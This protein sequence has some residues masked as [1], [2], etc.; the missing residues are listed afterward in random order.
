MRFDQY[1]Q[2]AAG[3]TERYIGVKLEKNGGPAQSS[4]QALSRYYILDFGFGLASIEKILRHIVE[5]KFHSS[6]IEKKNFWYS[7]I[8]TPVRCSIY[9]RKT[10]R[11]FSE[12]KPV[13]IVDIDP[14]FAASEK[15]RVYDIQTYCQYL[16]S[17]KN[18]GPP[19]YITGRALNELMQPVRAEDNGIYMLD[20]A[21]RISAHALAHQDS[22]NAL[23]IMQDEEFGN[24]ID[25]DRVNGLQKSIQK[26]EWFNNYQHIPMAGLKGQRTN[27]RFELMDLSLLQDASVMDFGCNLGQ[28]C[29]KA[30]QAGAKSVIG[31]E[32]MPDTFKLANA[33]KA[34]CTLDPI[35]YLN[36]DFN[37]PAFD[38]LIDRAVPEAVD[39]SFFFSVYRT[40]E[41]IQRDRLF[42]YIIH[43]S[44][45]G[46]F[47]EGHAHA[48]IDTIE[49]YD[50]LFESHGLKYQ[51]LGHSE[52]RL[53]P[54]FYLPLHHHQKHQPSAI[55]KTSLQM[56]AQSGSTPQKKQN[57]IPYLVSAVV[58]T[59][60]S[61]KFIRQ[62]LDDLLGQTI[63]DRL[64]IIVIDSNSPENEG[65]VCREYM[66]RHANI[67]YLRTDA[68][69]TVYQAWNRG[70]QMASGK[71]VTN[72]NTDDRLR[73]DALALLCTHLEKNPDV[74]LVYSD[75]FITHW[76]NMTFERHIRSGYSIKPDYSPHI[77]LQGCHIGPQP[78]WRRSVHDKIG[79][80]SPK[81]ESAGDYEFWCRMATSGYQL[82]HVNDFL[83]LYLHNPAGIINRNQMLAHK[84]TAV[85]REMY[86]H[87]LPEAASGL[88]TG[89]YHHEPARP[90]RYVNI[91]MV[92][93]NRLEFT[94]LAIQSILK[95]TRF[96]YVLTVVDNNS[97]DGSREYLK[98]LKEKGIVTNLLL[99]EDNFGVAKAANMGWLLEPDAEFYLK[100]DNDIVIQKID[101][102]TDLIRAVEQI[103][104]A[105]A[106]A[107]N[108]EPFSY[109]LR[110]LHGIKIRPKTSGNL[111]GACICIPR[112]TNE[113]LG[114]WSEEYG[115]Y[116]EE[117]ADYGCRIPLVGMLNLYMQDENIGLHLPAGRA[118]AIDENMTARDGLEERMHPR[119][120][121]YKDEQRRKNVLTHKF[122]Q[123][124]Q[125]YRHGEAPLFHDAPFARSYLKNRGDLPKTTHPKE[126]SES[127]RNQLAGEPIRKAKRFLSRD[128]GNHSKDLNIAVFSFEDPFTA[129]S[130][131]RLVAPFQGLKKHRLTWCA[132]LE[133]SELRIKANAIQDADVIVI[134]RGFPAVHTKPLLDAVFESGHPVVYEMDDLLIDVPHTNPFFEVLE[135]QKPF[136]LDTLKRASAVT[137]ATEPLKQK[138]LPY[139]SNIHVLPNLVSS[140]ENKPKEPSAT[141][142][143]VIGYAGT[144]THQADIGI[145][146]AALIRIINTYGDRVRLVSFG[147]AAPELSRLSNHQ[148][149]AF[150]PRYNAYLQKLR[151]LRFDI[152]LAPLE[153]NTFNQ[154]KSNIKWLEYAAAGIAGVYSN[155][156]PYNQCI[157]NEGTGMLVDDNAESWFKAISS[158]MGD[159][160]KRSR[161]SAR[162]YQQVLSDYC[163]QA[164]ATLWDDTYRTIIQQHRFN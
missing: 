35:E 95:H 88:P 99:L 17:G 108:F 106:V 85:I 3:Q 126:S 49:Y 69:E 157:Q 24:L 116:S 77:M 76:E 164:K 83:G 22:L 151:S 67:K 139:N 60:K 72:A 42:Q 135:R 84:E 104:E 57:E 159:P 70:I 133:G 155:I 152:A 109:P 128:E 111:G 53:R 114:Y 115:L 38:A 124:I 41:L 86:R 62:K 14:Q 112:R 5:T 46:V 96:P 4:H 90:G 74:A 131:L 55:S 144:A 87:R 63:A 48:K 40:K 65:D 100:F 52:G 80:F 105:G 107:Y 145:V 134:Q 13:S 163:L 121:A 29:I 20:G 21:R 150:E 137:V 8:I 56:K 147:C 79:Y 101:W 1:S 6:W 47:F 11:L 110:T 23:L 92:T 82:A 61:E 43:K 138:L 160:E 98:A 7:K 68:R 91:T 45:K 12:L 10:G 143:V 59:Y 44:R 158:L 71:Y 103:P 154:C 148:M 81:F 142:P 119:Y 2:P 31:I 19:L 113:R 58:S 75:F 102:L 32:G 97:T 117:D 51:F 54:L 94:R 129:C 162:A 149:V 122:A 123:N 127:N 28:A 78:V 16:I 37:H 34:L 118:A 18:L 146:E 93:F 89:F 26:L 156:L 120:R 130:H 27:R 136:L 39:Y 66:Q 50:W 15:D 140:Q 153:K 36:I 141:G 30:V 132:R 9:H 64:E 161:I 125:K 33:I 25:S 73:R